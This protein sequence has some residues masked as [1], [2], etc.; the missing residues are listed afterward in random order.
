VEHGE[1]GELTGQEPRRS[2]RSLIGLGHRP[3]GSA[4][5]E[6]DAGGGG[7]N[8]VDMSQSDWAVGRR[9]ARATNLT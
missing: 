4:Q 9:R 1:D 2:E 7:A 6:A 5:V 8:W 3:G